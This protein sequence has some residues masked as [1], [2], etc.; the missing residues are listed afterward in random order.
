V[1]TDLRVGVAAGEAIGQRN[2]ILRRVQGRLGQ[3]A[4]WPASTA[5][6]VPVP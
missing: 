6:T 5:T 2:Q 1:D 3:A 4:V